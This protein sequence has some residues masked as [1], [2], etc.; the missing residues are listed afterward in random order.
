[1]RHL[2]FPTGGSVVGTKR[3]LPKIDTVETI[4]SA[5]AGTNILFAAFD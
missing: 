5:D 4:G 3:R 2:K 1:M